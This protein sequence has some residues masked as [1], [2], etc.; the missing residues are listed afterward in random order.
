MKIWS[1]HTSIKR[2]IRVN[3]FSS[4]RMASW[5]RGRRLAREIATER[6]GIFGM[7]AKKY[8]GSQKRDK[9]FYSNF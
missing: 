2:Q 1:P 6:K 3:K 8:P 9:K 7:F 5:F 4:S